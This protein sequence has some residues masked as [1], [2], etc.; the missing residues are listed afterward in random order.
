[1]SEYNGYVAT[2][3]L[4]GATQD[5]TFKSME[6]AKYHNPSFG[7]WHQTIIYEEQQ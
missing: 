6:Q 4:T 3:K 1:M 2:H 5:F 7:D